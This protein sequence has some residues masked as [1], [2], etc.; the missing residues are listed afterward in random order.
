M[1]E[2]EKQVTIFRI[3]GSLQRGTDFRVIKTSK[4]NKFPRSL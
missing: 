2:E 4:Y 3:L 1:A